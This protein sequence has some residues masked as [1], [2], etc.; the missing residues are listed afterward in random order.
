MKTKELTEKY[1]NERDPQTSA[2][3]EEEA[4]IKKFESTMKIVHNFWK[5]SKG[6]LDPAQ[7]KN[8]NAALEMVLIHITPRKK[9][10]R[11]GPGPRL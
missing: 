10:K 1:L 5:R 4:Q 3:R 9:G 11:V 7:L 8:A 6:N 2:P